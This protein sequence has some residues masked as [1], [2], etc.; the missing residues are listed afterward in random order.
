[1]KRANVAIFVPHAGCPHRCTFCDQRSIAGA[2]AVPSGEEV[3]ATL[4]AAAGSLGERMRSAE[5]AFFGGSFTAIPRGEML[6]LLE[7]ARPFLGPEGFAGIRVST[8]PDAVDGEVLDILADF[9]V[10]AVELGAQSMD[11]RVLAACG[12]GHTA[13]D[14]VRASGMLRARGFSLGLQMMTGL[15][16]SDDAEARAT[17]DAL[18]ALRPDTVRIYPAL[19]LEGTPL[20]ALWRA[21]EYA[22]QTLESAMALCAGLLE[23]FAQRGVRV[24]RLGLHDSPDLRRSLLAGPHHPAFRE[25]CEGNV[26]LRRA[27]AALESIPPGS[28]TLAVARGSASK[29]AGQ[30]RANLAELET[31]GYRVK[32]REEEAIPYLEVRASV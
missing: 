16:C 9:G 14:V 27:L 22:P 26:L 7:A 32:I 21:G 8:R 3:A 6:R 25:L 12:R 20:A 18:I 17:A 11:D 4:R 5:I 2:A 28:V 31:R 24:I 15:P 13:A 10:T 23:R 1:M 19:V 29:M 30:R